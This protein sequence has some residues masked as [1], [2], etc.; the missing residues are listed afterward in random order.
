MAND[1]ARSINHPTGPMGDGLLHS[2]LAGCLALLERLRADME[3]DEK[4]NTDV[5]QQFDDAVEAYHK[6]L[7]ERFTADMKQSGVLE[8]LQ[9]AYV[10]NPAAATAMQRAEF[11]KWKK[12]QQRTP[13]AAAAATAA[14]MEVSHA[15]TASAAKH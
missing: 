15:K 8:T 10:T 4:R 3:Y 11:D 6:D 2:S 7:F 9:S 13:T 5:Q 14:P 12:Q 1:P